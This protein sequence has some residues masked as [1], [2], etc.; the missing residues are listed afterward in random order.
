M[1][2]TAIVAGGGIGGLAAAIALATAGLEVQLFEREP[3]LRAPG[4]GIAMWPNGQ[5][6]LRLLGLGEWLQPFVDAGGTTQFRS[7]DGRVLAQLDTETSGGRHGKQ[8]TLHRQE[9]LA[10]LA[11]RAG[12]VGVEV[13]YGQPIGFAASDGTVRGG[14]EELRA[15]LVIGADGI[16]SAVRRT[17]FPSAPVPRWTDLA[18]WRW[19][20][21]ME[22]AGVAENPQATEVLGPG[23]EFGFLPIDA[24][25]AYCFASSAPLPD[26]TI[27]ELDEYAQ[28]ADPVRSAV[29]FRPLDATIETTIGYLPPLRSYVS[30]HIALLGDAAHAMT[31][32]VGQGSCMALE[33][34]VVL[35][36]LVGKAVADGVQPRA[37]LAEYDKVRRPRCTAMQKNSRFGMSVMGATSPVLC[38][39]RNRLMHATPNRLFARQIGRNLD[40]AHLPPLPAAQ[41]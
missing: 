17:A 27:A 31:P 22:A 25:R 10:A 8:A 4:A 21:D 30:G 18:T 32:H 37:A 40:T 16:G 23:M 7:P 35:G 24:R 14:G 41:T 15:D 6:C 26:G 36:D 11:Q 12:E 20:L 39:A 29:R 5:H 28:W 34:A 33:D 2:A 19:I 3:Q 13:R 9:L 1:G 38:A